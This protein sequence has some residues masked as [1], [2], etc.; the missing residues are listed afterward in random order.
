[1]GE[2]WP[3]DGAPLAEWKIGFFG[4]CGIKDCGL[5]PCFIPNA[6]A[7]GCLQCTYASATT[8][9]VANAK[10]KA[11]AAD[12]STAH[13]DR[14]EDWGGNYMKSCLCITLCPYC[15]TC[16]SRGEIIQHYGIQDDMTCIKGFCCPMCSYYQVLNEIMVR[17]NLKFGIVSVVPDTDSPP[18]EDMETEAK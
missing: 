1:M 17:E 7:Y 13:I 3:A 18:Q 12:G 16:I 6:V 10:A 15:T 9:V 8:T 2:Q 11:A 4:C 14:L 5:F